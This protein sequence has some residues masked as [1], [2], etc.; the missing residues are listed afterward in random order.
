MDQHA[1]VA[2]HD[3]GHP[4]SKKKKTLQKCNA[5]SKLMHKSPQRGEREHKNMRENKK[6]V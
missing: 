4:L 3:W 2:E 1:D 5:H 6:N